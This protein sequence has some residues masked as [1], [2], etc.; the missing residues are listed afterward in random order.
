MKIKPG[1]SIAGVQPELV[2]AM[3]VINSVYD[4]WNIEY[5][6]TSVTDSEHKKHSLHY[7][8]FAQDSRT[9]DFYQNDLQDVAADLRF[10]LGDEFDVILESDHFHIE[11]QPMKGINL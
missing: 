2:V 6:L 1:V 10:S 7:V 11:F 8:G 5:V 9:R 4:K 3:I